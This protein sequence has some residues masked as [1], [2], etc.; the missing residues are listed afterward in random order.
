MAKQK[1]LLG[2][3]SQEISPC[4]NGCRADDLIML[5][6]EALR[7]KPGSPLR[8]PSLHILALI[9]KVENCDEKKGQ[10][11]VVA[12]V[13]LL[14]GSTG[15]APSW[16]NMH[17]TELGMCIRAPQN[18]RDRLCFVY[19]VY[20]VLHLMELQFNNLEL[21]F[22][23]L[24]YYLKILLS[25]HKLVLLKLCIMVGIIADNPSLSLRFLEVNEW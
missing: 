7:L 14:S 6:K 3:L 2:Q 19:S 18:V 23:T 25:F 13:N 1:T 21:R 9:D 10:K 8:P 5:T 12:H 17:I 15:D 22:K 20:H 11:L 4:R 16:L 24:E